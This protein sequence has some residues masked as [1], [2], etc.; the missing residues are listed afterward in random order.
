MSLGIL[1]PKLF[2]SYSWSSPEHESFVVR[3]AA[4]LTES[5]IHVVFDK[6]DLKEGQDANAFMEKMVN[7]P[8]ILKVAMLCDSTY[9]RKADERKGGVGTESQILS[10][11][12][13]AANNE[14][15]FVAVVLE[16][17]DGGRAIV[18]TFYS[19]RIYIDLSDVSHYEAEFERL[20]R[21]VFNKPLYQRPEMGDAPS[22]LSETELVSSGT[23]TLARRA[24]A[25]IKDGRP[26][27]KATLREY[28]C[29]V[30]ESLKQ[31]RVELGLAEEEADERVVAM[32][33][34]ML[35]LRDEIVGVFSMVVIYGDVEQTA[36]AAHQ[37]LED[38]LPL[39]ERPDE[40]T[41]WP[42][43]SADALRFFLHELFLHFVA[44]SLSSERWDIAATLLGQ[45]YYSEKAAEYGRPQ[46]SSYAVF[47]GGVES[48]VIRNQ[49]LNLQRTSLHA[50][51][52]KAR[53]EH[54]TVSLTQLMEADFVAYL[55]AVTT[56]ERW[57][58]I[59]LLYATFRYSG[60][61]KVFAKAESRV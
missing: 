27:A 34:A 58:P 43:Y 14:N 10:K 22:Y 40:I 26:H 17:D 33:D 61:F 1:A 56:G 20:V 3:L 52:I 35:P 9:K 60:A 59:T 21:W 31:F 30:A 24:M 47:K 13:Y 29:A 39:L 54:S 15:K 44:I 4:E 5:G 38:A 12:I 46:I 48:L 18:P 55:R 45:G 28:F 23:S 2:L 8:E 49:R 53:A 41:A 36:G 37:F 16:K 51:F 6:W 11:E 42:Q 25:A 57:W 50:D 7:D 32:V 19:S